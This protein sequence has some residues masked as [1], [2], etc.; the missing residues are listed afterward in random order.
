[1]VPPEHPFDLDKPINDI[2]R[3]SALNVEST[4]AAIVF[5]DVESFTTK[6]SAD[7]KHALK[8]IERDY[9]V[10]EQ[11]CHRF[12]GQILK[13]L[14]DGLL[15]YF[16]DTENAVAC[17]I[18]IQTAFAQ[19][20][21]QRSPRDILRHRIGIHRG[22]VL[23]SG[24]DVMGNGV[25]IAARLQ[26]ESPPGGVGISH[27]VYDVVKGRLKFPAVY[28]GLR[29][30]KGIKEAIPVYHVPPPRQTPATYHVFISYRAK[31]PD[32]DIAQQFYQALLAAGCSAFMAGESIQLG[33]NWAQRI[34]SELKRCDYLLLL[35]SEQSASSEM[36][37]EE[38]KRA[39]ELQD[40]REDN[41]PFILPIRINFPLN[42]P[43]TYTLQGYLER[44]QQRAW[45]SESDTSTLIQEVL[46]VI[47]QTPVMFASPEFPEDP[48]ENPDLISQVWDQSSRFPLPAATPEIPEGQVDLD[49]AFYIER[50]PIEQR[51]QEAI[52]QPGS[53]IRIKAPRQMGKT[54][55]MARVLHSATQQGHFAVPLS[56]QLA[57]GKIFS[58]LDKLLRWFCASVGRRLKLPNRLNDYWDDIFGSKDNCTAY[59]EE[60]LLE[61]IDCPLTLGLDEVDC[62]FQYP[63]IAADF[64]GLLRAWHEDA[65]SRDIWKNFR[66]V[67]VH[68]TEVYVPMDIN[69]SPFNVGMPVELP[70]FTGEQVYD[71][72]QLHGLNWT[73]AEVRELM[74]LV[75]GHPYLVRLALY[76][77]AHQDLTLDELVRSGTTEAGL[78]SDHLRRHLW[79]LEQNSS[80]LQAMKSVVMAQSAVRL[81]PA[82]AFKL[83]SVG[84]VQLQGNDVLPRC[85]LYRQYLSDR[86]KDR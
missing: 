68:A 36:V 62:V 76:H 43:L 26:K 52:Q 10:M 7:E 75:G 60:Y 42:A 11:E 72:V 9:L 24:N 54:S 45:K 57:D 67:V 82:Q 41:K 65:K 56:F 86:L 19:A 59:F 78:Y 2:T 74:S 32:L 40:I 79:S 64:F 77:L 30:L 51:C 16:P 47:H 61:Q 35:L 14:G 69:Q 1:M 38:V 49:S 71:L 80:L 31:H 21:A 6:M 33:A 50:P 17:A 39:K 46:E 58:D 22:E 4:L 12:G 85:N 29:K 13:S 48:E 3:P 27:S 70:E 63:D 66:L 55:L 53:L 28:V 25:N 81:D 83:H 44:I 15:I 84:L 73:M 5:T 20:S 37:T 8:L 18:A 34:E 23:F